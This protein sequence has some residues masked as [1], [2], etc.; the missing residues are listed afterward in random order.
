[1]KDTTITFRLDSN[2][3]EQLKEMAATQ[4][5][6]VSHLIYRLLKKGLM[7]REENVQLS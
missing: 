5:I 6:S 2:M 1:M 3:K 4:D 7:E